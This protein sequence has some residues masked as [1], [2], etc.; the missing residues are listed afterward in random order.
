L[1]QYTEAV[2]GGREAETGRHGHG[3]PIARAVQAVQAAFIDIAKVSFR[4]TA[5]LL[6]GI[7]AG[8]AE[9]L[10]HIAGEAVVLA[11][12]IGRASC[13]ERVS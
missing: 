10:L 5:Y 2:C 1:E 7:H 3:R 4:G 9:L 11:Q 13:R 12:Q 8:H 6:I